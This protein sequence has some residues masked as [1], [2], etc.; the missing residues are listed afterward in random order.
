MENT[1][2]NI[3]ANVNMKYAESCIKSS[4]KVTT[5]HYYNICTGENYAVPTGAYDYMI[6]IPFFLILVGIVLGL[7]RMVFNRFY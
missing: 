3:N 1:E 5:T 4:S 7:F 2:Q 6:G